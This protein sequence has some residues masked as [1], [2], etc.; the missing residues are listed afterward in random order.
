MNFDFWPS[1]QTLISIN[2]NLL[3]LTYLRVWFQLEFLFI[4]LLNS[5]CIFIN[6]VFLTSF[7]SQTFPSIFQFEFVALRALMPFLT[8]TLSEI[9]QLTPFS[10]WIDC[11]GIF[12]YNLFLNLNHFD[13]M[14]N[15]GIRSNIFVL[16]LLCQRKA[17]NFAR[18]G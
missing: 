15:R 18:F 8:R 17:A 7:N 9:A 1:Q 10:I 14:Q 3:K 2:V 5:V 13:S 11:M 12:A 16:L 6:S 4:C